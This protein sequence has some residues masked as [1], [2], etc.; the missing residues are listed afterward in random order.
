MYM[1]YKQNIASKNVKTSRK[2]LISD[3]TKTISEGCIQKLLIILTICQLI[4]K[5]ITELIAQAYESIF[6]Y[7]LNYVTSMER[8]CINAYAILDYQISEIGN[9][10]HYIRNND[11]I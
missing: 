7:G 6:K 4:G 8:N 2:T 3:K 9:R 5:T 11:V 10:C 1:N